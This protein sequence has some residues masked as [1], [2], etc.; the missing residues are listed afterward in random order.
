MDGGLSKLEVCFYNNNFEIR[1]Y[2]GVSNYINKIKIDIIEKF[3]MRQKYPVICE[4]VEKLKPLDKE[5]RK[6]FADIMINFKNSRSF[7]IYLYPIL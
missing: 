7:R 2:A 6:F 1:G 5:W 4:L 3:N